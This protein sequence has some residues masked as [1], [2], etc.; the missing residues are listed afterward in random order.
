MQVGVWQDLMILM[1]NV[2]LYLENSNKGVC[3]CRAAIEPCMVDDPHFLYEEQPELERFCTPS[4]SITLLTDWY[5]S[6]VQE[7]EHNSHQV[8]THTLT[9]IVAMLSY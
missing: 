5:L 1:E 6:R 8:H 7:I 3:V 2:K 4:P 9:H